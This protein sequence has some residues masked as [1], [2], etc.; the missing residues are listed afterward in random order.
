MA[1]PLIWLLP[2]NPSFSRNH[3]TNKLFLPISAPC[4]HH[5]SLPAELAVS[6]LLYV[7]ASDLAVSGIQQCVQVLQGCR[8]LVFESSQQAALDG[9]E[10]DSPL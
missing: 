8:G 9:S 10:L 6:V 4:E 1:N 7:G 5:L 3:T 2:Q